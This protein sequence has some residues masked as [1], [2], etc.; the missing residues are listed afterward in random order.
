MGYYGL[1][2]L[3]VFYPVWRFLESPS[4]ILEKGKNYVTGKICGLTFNFDVVVIN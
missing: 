3:E 1:N 4:R 2:L